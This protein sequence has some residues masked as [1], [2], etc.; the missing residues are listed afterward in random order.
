MDSFD[1]KFF[2]K[3]D[4]EGKYVI[5]FDKY[6]YYLKS[7]IYNMKKRTISCCVINAETNKTHKIEIEEIK[8]IIMG[9][10]GNKP[11]NCAGVESSFYND[12][13]ELYIHPT[14]YKCIVEDFGVKKKYYKKGSIF[15]QDPWIDHSRD[16]NIYFDA[17]EINF[18]CK[19]DKLYLDEEEI[20]I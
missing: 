11:T 13:F 18:Q 14:Q 9:N 2:L 7:I 8:Y 12:Q 5:E 17:D 19:A 10:Y 16:F 15:R 6:I 4:E 3:E 20:L 1:L